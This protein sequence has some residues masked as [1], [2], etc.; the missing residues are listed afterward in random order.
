MLDKNIVLIM[1]LVTEME[2][3]NIMKTLCKSTMTYHN[4]QERLMNSYSIIGQS[5]LCVLET[6]SGVSDHWG[7]DAQQSGTL[8]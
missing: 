3:R 6:L 1:F 8:K 4:V 2:N 5:R 7:V